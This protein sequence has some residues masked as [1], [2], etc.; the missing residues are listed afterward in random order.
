MSEQQLGEETQYA[1]ILGDAMRGDGS[2]FTR[3]DAV[4]AAWRAVDTVRANHP[5]AQLYQ[6]GS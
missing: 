4:E 2:L 6:R 1:R 3:E 5:R